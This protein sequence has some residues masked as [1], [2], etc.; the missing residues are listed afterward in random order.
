[1]FL[2]VLRWAGN[3]QGVPTSRPKT[4]GIC[5][6]TKGQ[7]GRQWM[8]VLVKS[9]L[10]CKGITLQGRNPFICYQLCP[11]CV[12]SKGENEKN[13][14]ENLLIK[15]LIQYNCGLSRPFVRRLAH[16]WANPHHS[17]LA[18]PETASDILLWKLAVGVGSLAVLRL[19]ACHLL[20]NRCW[21]QL[22][23]PV[24]HRLEQNPKHLSKRVLS[25]C[26]MY[27]VI[28]V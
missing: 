3:F 25:S 26:L 16:D 19:T 18:N 22:G 14:T 7:T 13:P 21:E 28:F 1:M 17:S 27:L 6:S 9:F 4:A 12:W 23:G 11:I 5:D 15:P 20:Q 10:R 24:H 2:N 8:D